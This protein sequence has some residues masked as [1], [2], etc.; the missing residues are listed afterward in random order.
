[1]SEGPIIAQDVAALLES[2]DVGIWVATAS[3]ECVPQTTRSMGA[4][5]DR[6]RGLVQLFVEVD[7]S[8]R[9]LANARPGAGIAATF[10][11]IYDYRAVQVKGRVVSARPCRD[12]ERPW[13]ERYLAGFADANARVGMPRELVEALKIWPCAVIELEVLELF[14]QTPGPSA[15]ARL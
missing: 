2:G 8:E 5:V 6:E 1:V 9:V 14:T 15:G 7:Q 12:E 11:R 4:R 13:T 3:V 10:V